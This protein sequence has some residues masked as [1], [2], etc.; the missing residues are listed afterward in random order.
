MA[1]GAVLL[2]TLPVEAASISINPDVGFRLE[3]DHRTITLLQ[4]ISQD[5]VE[6]CF[7]SVSEVI[8]QPVFNRDVNKYTAGALRERGTAISPIR[9]EEIFSFGT[10]STF[11]AITR[12][13]TFGN[14]QNVFVNSALNLQMEGNLSEDLKVSAVITDQNIPYQP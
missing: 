4:T 13:V 12:G 8:H 11:G 2:D 6:I 10:V 3:S 14:R 5:S 9:E 1:E 7:R